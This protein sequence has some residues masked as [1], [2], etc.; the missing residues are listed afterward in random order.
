MP[1]NFPTGLDASTFVADPGNAGAIPLVDAQGLAASTDCSLVT[2]GA[3]TR[4]IAAPSFAGQQCRLYFLTDGGN[5]VTTVAA[6]FNV[7]GNTILTMAAAGNSCTLEAF[8][9]TAKATVAWRLVYNDGAT[10]S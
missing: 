9:T 7:A 3:E 6:A 10:L 4:T 1:S 5:A 8:S 2:A